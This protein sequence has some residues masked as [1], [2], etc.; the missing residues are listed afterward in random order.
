MISSTFFTAVAPAALMLSLA[1]MGGM[2]NI[3][4]KGAMTIKNLISSAAVV[5]VPFM[6]DSMADTVEKV[7]YKVK[8]KTWALT[9]EALA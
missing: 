9:F 1:V 7:D 2:T 5:V 6:L 4:W 3:P 8:L